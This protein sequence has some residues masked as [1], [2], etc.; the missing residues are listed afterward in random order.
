M[1]Q[2]AVDGSSSVLF[3]V[4]NRVAIVTLSRPKA[5]NAL[6]HD[7]IL[8]LGAI[9]RR[10]RDDSEVVAV[11]LRG[12]GDKAF[13]A[14][15]DVRSLYEKALSND[16]NWVQFF[17]DEYRLDYAI[18]TFPKPVIA[19][20]DGITMGGGMGLAQGA[21]LRVATERSKLAMPE[22]RIGLVPDVGASHFLSRL[23]AGAALYLALSGATLSGPE[24]VS[25]GLADV[26]VPSEWLAGFEERLVATPR[27]RLDLAVPDVLHR[28]LHT[29][30]GAGPQAETE[31][32]VPRLL[33]AIN[34]HFAPSKAV[35]DIVQ[36]LADSVE[37][38]E[39]S[40]RKDWLGRTRDA[41]ANNS[42]LML[43]VTRESILRGREAPLGECFR[44]ELDV[45][46]RCVE[47]G[48]FVEGVRAR[49]IDKDNRPAWRPASLAEV[50]QDRVRHFLSSPWS[51]SNHPL[52]DI[53]RN[54]P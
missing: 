22:A 42:P 43:H 16:R 5:L 19:L 41:L 54:F 7:M 26:C 6:S 45:V 39:D 28:S 13:C 52:A 2:S 37:V 27:S 35:T 38:E 3:R 15:G 8:I 4:V 32:S 34:A 1:A 47:E 46:M 40:V 10:C 25:L 20:L 36:S 50:D 9:L 49:L 53:E 21:W 23:P 24:S 31:C 14:G 33:P 51:E 29:V 30:F 17:A 18:H 12:A 48:D 11:V 44:R